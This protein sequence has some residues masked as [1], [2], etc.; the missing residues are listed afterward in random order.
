MLTFEHA[1]VPTS[2]VSFFFPE[3][4]CTCCRVVSTRFFCVYFYTSQ[5]LLKDGPDLFEYSCRRTRARR[6]FSIIGETSSELL[7]WLAFTLN[8]EKSHLSTSKV[9]FFLWLLIDSKSMAISL[10]R[11]KVDTA[12]DSCKG[13]LENPSPSIREVAW[14]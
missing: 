11:V 3:R 12:V 13:L 14:V 4:L 2:L 8:F 5:K 7:T 6:Y 10:P 9:L 1:A